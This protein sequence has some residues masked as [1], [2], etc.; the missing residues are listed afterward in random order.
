MSDVA[1][2][3]GDMNRSGGVVRQYEDDCVRTGGSVQVSVGV[4][5]NDLERLHKA[6]MV[7]IERIGA[8]LGP[9][10]PRPAPD[11]PRDIDGTGCDLADELRAADRDVEMVIERLQ[12]AAER[13][14]L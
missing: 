13:V 11:V 7:L 5:Q 3:T 10:H 2:T 6:S 8:V 1:W 14:Q 9:D 12:N 4:L